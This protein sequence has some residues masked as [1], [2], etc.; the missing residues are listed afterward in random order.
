M[1]LKLGDAGRALACTESGS[2]RKYLSL[3]DLLLTVVVPSVAVV[4]M[5]L[6]RLVC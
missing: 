1:L 3:S 5:H 4:V 6:C 2:N